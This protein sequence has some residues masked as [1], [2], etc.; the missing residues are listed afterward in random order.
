MKG[1][2]ALRA[3]QNVAHAEDVRL[4]QPSSGGLQMRQHA[5]ADQAGVQG[6]QEPTVPIDEVSPAS[7][8]PEAFLRLETGPLGLD[9]LLPGIKLGSMPALEKTQMV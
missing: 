4:V 2:F 1:A 9:G 3:P 6:V 5:I 8:L 7:S